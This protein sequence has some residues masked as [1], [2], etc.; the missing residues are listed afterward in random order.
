MLKVISRFLIEAGEHSYGC[1]MG[2]FPSKTS[3]QIKTFAKNMIP[4]SA[5]FVD[6]DTK[7]METDIHVTVKYGIHTKDAK[8]VQKAV[9]GFGK[10]TIKLT[11]I[12]KFTPDDEEY[13]VLK[14]GVESLRLR[15]LNALVSRK[16]ENTDKHPIYNPHVTLA[17]VKKGTCQDL[18]G[19]KEFN[20]MELTFEDLEFNSSDDVNTKIQL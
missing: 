15:E 7:G 4:E 9:E 11:M 8:D 6:E 10:F 17:Y 5:V 19:S 12:S 16:L 18:V 3:Q 1:L 2:I 13:D 14:I 20:G